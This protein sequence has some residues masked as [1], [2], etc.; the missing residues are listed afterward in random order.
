[1]KEDQ[2]LLLDLKQITPKIKEILKK[3]YHSHKI[4]IN[5]NYAKKLHDFLH[6]LDKL[7]K[8]ENRKFIFNIRFIFF[9]Q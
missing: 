6:Y 1:M 7:L 9:K 5:S 4:N 2:Y 8:Y 3:S